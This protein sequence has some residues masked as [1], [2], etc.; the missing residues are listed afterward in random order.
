MPNEGIQGDKWGTY[1]AL[2]TFLGDG[3][4][5]GLRDA[6]PRVTEGSVAKFTLRRARLSLTVTYAAKA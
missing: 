3:T 6:S 1:V 4:W 5:D 2:D